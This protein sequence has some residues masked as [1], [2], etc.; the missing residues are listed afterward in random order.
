M[1]TLRTNI[2]KSKFSNYGS[3]IFATPTKNTQYFRRVNQKQPTMRGSFPKA[4]RWSLDDEGITNRRGD[5]NRAISINRSAR[6]ASRNFEVGAARKIGSAT[7]SSNVYSG[8]Q[9]PS[10]TRLSNISFFSGGNAK[11]PAYEGNVARSLNPQPKPEP[12]IEVPVTKAPELHAIKGSQ[13]QRS[14]MQSS[15][16][17]PMFVT[18]AKTAATLV[19]VIAILA[20]VRVGFTSATVSTG[21]NSQE[22]SNNIQ[23]ELVNKNALEVQDSTLGNSSRIRESASHYNLVTPAAIETINLGQDVLAY[24]DNKNVSLV[25]SLNRVAGSTK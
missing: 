18:L 3:S 24:D 17:S 12:K 14:L 11:A 25:E 20:F 6:L 21:L 10:Q 16:L 9:K 15:A 23:T 22:I 19:V 8:S 4:V 13:K 1:P 5:Y 2:Q 7:L